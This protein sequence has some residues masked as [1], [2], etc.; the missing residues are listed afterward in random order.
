MFSRGAIRAL[1]SMR[2]VSA[3]V[4][5]ALVLAV[6]SVAVVVI[7]VRELLRTGGK[8]TAQVRASTERL[9][10]LTEELQTEM[11]VTSVEIEGLSKAVE[12]LNK[13]RQTNV[14]R[15]QRSKAKRKG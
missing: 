5:L 3:F 14:K 13:Q 11:A 4:I 10:P 9:V 2:R 12:R 15:A 8:L 1:A 7:V 6:L